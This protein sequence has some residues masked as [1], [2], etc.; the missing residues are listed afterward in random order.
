ML[1]PTV[2]DHGDDDRDDD[3]D[4]D[5]RDDDAHD[6]CGV[7]DAHVG[8]VAAVVV[9]VAVEVLGDAVSVGALELPASARG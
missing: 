7:E 3:D 4:D 8:L 5:D 1:L 9:V 6:A 2:Q